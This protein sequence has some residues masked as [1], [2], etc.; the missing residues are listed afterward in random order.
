L[1]NE[2]QKKLVGVLQHHAMEP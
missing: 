1:A 2:C